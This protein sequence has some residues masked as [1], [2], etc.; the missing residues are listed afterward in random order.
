MFC[1]YIKY[2]WTNTLLKL[3][4]LKRKVSHNITPFTFLY[5]VKFKLHHCIFCG[6]CH[7]LYSLTSWEESITETQILKLEK[8]AQSRLRRSGSPS[9]R[10]NIIM[11]FLIVYFFGQRHLNTLP[12]PLKNQNKK[13]P[14]MFSAPASTPF[15]GCKHQ[16][17]LNW[18][19]W[20]FLL[21]RM[22]TQWLETH[23]CG[24]VF[25]PCKHWRDGTFSVY[26]EDV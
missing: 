21:E 20:V 18:H 19:L 2:S 9:D 4:C 23:T 22:S 8:R 14:N 3:Q 16:V 10:S 5:Q 13:K 11:D 6:V 17:C 25:F 7:S 24:N 1:I 26:D 15:I 12:P